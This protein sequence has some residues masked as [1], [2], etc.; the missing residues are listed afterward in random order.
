MSE[1]S[2]N[3]AVRLH[4]LCN[5]K[6]VPTK[7]K[8]RERV[9]ARQFSKSLTAIH[10]WLTGESWPSMEMLIAIC[11]W[12]QV[13]LDWLCYGKG[14]KYTAK[15]EKLPMTILADNLKTLMS[16]KKIS[17]TDVSNASAIAQ[18]QVSRILREKLETGINKLFNLAKA[19]GI[20]PWQ[21]LVPDL[22]PANL[23][24]LQLTNED[25]ARGMDISE[26]RRRNL[27]QLKGDETLVVFSKKVGTSAAYI[28]QILSPNMRGEV[29]NRFARQIEKYLG[30]ERGWM[31]HSHK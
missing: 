15:P 12:A 14:D 21:L 17:Q 1:L 28:C 7:G 20:E 25:F 2:K 26:I 18:T 11:E 10:K 29:G 19:L 30:L 6:G 22:D 3:F 9:L 5:E 31:D 27:L 23:P 8:G 4:E 13:R 24:A 16:K